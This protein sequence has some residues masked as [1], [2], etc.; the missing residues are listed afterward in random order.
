M[1]HVLDVP[2]A[3]YHHH[4]TSLHVYERDIESFKA[5]QEWK[6]WASGEERK[7][8]ESLYP[9]GNSTEFHHAAVY[10]E[11]ETFGPRWDQLQRHTYPSMSVIQARFRQML[12]SIRAGQHFSP[13]N[14][15]EGWY[16]DILKEGA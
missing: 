5:V 3:T 14:G 8:F 1:A 9:N 11:R 7:Q 16:Y 2:A 4:A 10:N 15:V 13:A 12:S 6:E